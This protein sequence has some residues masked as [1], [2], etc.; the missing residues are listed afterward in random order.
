[1]GIFFE[2][3]GWAGSFCFLF[4]FYML[5]VKKWTTDNRIY[6]W[7]N[8]AGSLL[9]VTNGAYYLAWAV[10]FINFAWGCI[11]CFGLYKTYKKKEPG[12]K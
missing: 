1:M 12:S 2:S 6:H 10:I 8:I 9:F 5:I 7:Y 3:L 11:A 4:A